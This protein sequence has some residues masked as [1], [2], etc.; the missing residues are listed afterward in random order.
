MAC[1]APPAPAPPSA[2]APSRPSYGAAAA[3]SLPADDANHS[4]TPPATPPLPGL[5]HRSGRYRICVCF[6][7]CRSFLGCRRRLC[8]CLRRCLRFGDCLQICSCLPC[9][10]QT[11]HTQHTHIYTLCSDAF[12]TLC[13]HLTHKTGT[14]IQNNRNELW[15]LLHFIMPQL[16]DSQDSFQEWFSKASVVCVFATLL[17]VCSVH[18]CV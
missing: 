12:N 8:R 14:P 4:V 13:T 15:A 1:R 16:F 5:P 10:R 6:C 3:Y 11:L 18:V 2:T 17:C 7:G 9:L